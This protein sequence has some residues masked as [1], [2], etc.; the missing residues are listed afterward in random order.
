MENENNEI[1]TSL[2]E[3]AVDTLKPGGAPGESKAVM[4]DTFVQLLAQL[5]KED[6]SDIFNQVQ[7]Q[8]GP[9]NAPGAV[10]MAAKNA[11]TIAAKPSA[12]T[13]IKED[14]DGLFEGEELTEELKEKATVIFEAAVNTRVNLE[15]ARLA[16]EYSELETQLTEEF[17]EK[18]VEATA[19][20]TESLSEKLDQYIDYVVENWMEEN[21][22]AVEGG[23]RT[24]IA[25]NFIQGLHNLFSEH[26]ITVPDNKIDLVAEM[27]AELDE[28]RNQLNESIDRNIEL[29]QSLIESAKTDII[30]EAAHGLAR[31]QVEKLAMLAEGVEF[32]DIDSFRRKVSIIKESQFGLKKSATPTGLI[33]ESI[34]GEETHQEAPS[35]SEP[36]IN[37]YVNALSKSKV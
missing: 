17:E 23:I 35:Y 16:E 4:L 20:I 10:D 21:A 28:V 3:A 2:E 29:E 9:N 14:I 7:A 12:A 1:D 36:S 27:K 8:Y 22:L 26:Y 34:A 5:G 25:E 19:E 13:A 15:M 30:E 32:T 37:A 31:T 6:L 33:T 11:A 24:E 18:L